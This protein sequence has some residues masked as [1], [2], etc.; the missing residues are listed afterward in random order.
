MDGE[1]LVEYWDLWGCNNEGKD[2]FKLCLTGLQ[3]SKIPKEVD[4]P[5]AFQQDTPCSLGPPSFRAD[6]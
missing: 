3:W 5:H 6:M 2:R 1:S 4:K